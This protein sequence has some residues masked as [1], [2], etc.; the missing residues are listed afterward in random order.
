MFRRVIARYERDARLDGATPETSTEVTS[1]TLTGSQGFCET[2]Q[3]P[4]VP[5]SITQGG[6]AF[7][8]NGVFADTTITPGDCFGDLTGTVSG[9]VVTFNDILDEVV[10][11]TGDCTIDGSL[12]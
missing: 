5:H 2:V 3:F 1:L 6:G 8:V 10:A 9:G 12:S 11:S 4:N 7:Q